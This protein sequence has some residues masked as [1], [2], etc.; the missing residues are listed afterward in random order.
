MNLSYFFWV[1]IRLKEHIVASKQLCGKE[2]QALELIAIGGQNFPI[3]KNEI[4]EGFKN[5]NWQNY[6]YL[7]IYQALKYD[8]RWMHNIGKKDGC[9]D[10]FAL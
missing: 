9:K 4:I 7:K 1:G 3:S 5:R 6:P 10:N 2:Q 8:S